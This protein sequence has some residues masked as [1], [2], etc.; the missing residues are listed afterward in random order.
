[1]AESESMDDL[2][3]STDF[4][5]RELVERFPQKSPSSLYI[6]IFTFDYNLK[7]IGYYIYI[8]I[9]LILILT[10]TDSLLLLGLD[11]GDI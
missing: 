9:S 6:F 5:P 8:T 4:F 10:I 11:G 1:M 2:M 3:I 7:S